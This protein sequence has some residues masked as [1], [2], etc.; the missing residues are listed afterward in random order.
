MNLF[1]H[2][3]QP[4]LHKT[5]L[6]VNLIN[7]TNTYSLGIAGWWLPRIIAEVVHN[8]T[9]NIRGGRGIISVVFIYLV[10]QYWCT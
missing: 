10:I 9:V 2:L 3:F 5:K 4:I 1:L 6:I 8:R 7:I